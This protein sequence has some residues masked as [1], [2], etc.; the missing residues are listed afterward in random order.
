[1]KKQTLALITL[2]LSGILN[3]SAQEENS[4]GTTGMFFN[5]GFAQQIGGESN[6]YTRSKMN[7]CFEFGAFAESKFANS[8][9]YAKIEFSYR[10][11]NAD[12]K[13]GDKIPGIAKQM[14]PSI[15]FKVG[16]G[17]D[18]FKCYLGT[19]IYTVAQNRI[20]DPVFSDLPKIKDGFFAYWGMNVELEVQGTI[21]VD[22][23]TTGVSVRF[24]VQPPFTIASKKDVPKFYHSGITLGI[25]FGA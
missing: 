15:N 13:F 12:Y 8:N 17:K 1:M 6:D 22:R 20:A 5:Y 16:R 7:N 9:T 2:L 21:K 3:I 4:K 19:G 24:F 11:L 25:M 18:N 14:V 23:Y 10:F